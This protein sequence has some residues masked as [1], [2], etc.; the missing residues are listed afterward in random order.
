[1]LT[2]NKLAKNSGKMPTVPP[3]LK[4]VVTLPCKKAGTVRLQCT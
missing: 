1:M 4:S 3:L 2:L